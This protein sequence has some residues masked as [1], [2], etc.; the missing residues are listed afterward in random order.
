MAF[1]GIKINKIYADLLS[2]VQVSGIPTDPKNMHLTLLFLGKN[3]DIKDIS[4]TIPLIHEKIK[5]I[6]SFS[7]DITGIDYLP[8]NAGE[9]IPTVV[10]VKS[11]AINHLRNELTQ[12]FNENNFFYDKTYT[13]FNPHITLSYSEKLSDALW[14][15][16]TLPKY[17]LVDNI[18]LWAGKENNNISVNFPLIQ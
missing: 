6:K 14:S 10:K 15:S 7:A 2:K 4:K 5:N 11:D 16:E 17:F 1:I 9:K 8:Q 18:A 12:S 3:Y 13:D